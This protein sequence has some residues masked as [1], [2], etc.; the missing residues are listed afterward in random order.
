MLSSRTRVRVTAHNLI[1]KKSQINERLLSARSGHPMPG[2]CGLIWP[3]ASAFDH[4][5]VIGI[6]S[7]LGGSK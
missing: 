1:P 6:G 4:F 7:S 5:R 2:L 3:F